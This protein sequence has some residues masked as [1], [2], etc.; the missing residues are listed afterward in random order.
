MKVKYFIDRF[1]SQLGMELDFNDDECQADE[2]HDQCP[3]LPSKKRESDALAF[4]PEKSIWESPFLS[5]DSKF[6]NTNFSDAGSPILAFDD[7]TNNCTSD[8]PRYN[9][10][11]S[12]SPRYND[13]TSDNPR[14][15]DSTTDSPRYNDSTTDSPRYKTNAN[16]RTNDN[17][18]FKININDNNTDNFNDGKNVMNSIK[19]TSL[20]TQNTVEKKKLISKVSYNLCT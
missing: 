4:K 19:Q 14:Y 8:S 1:Q 15:N 3:S 16:D 13:S 7:D 12:D 11:T 10:S 5:A 17:L 20:S 9:D 18:G 2:T 6:E